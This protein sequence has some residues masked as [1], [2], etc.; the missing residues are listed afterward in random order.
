MLLPSALTILLGSLVVNPLWFLGFCMKYVRVVARIPEQDVYDSA[1]ALFQ[2]LLFVAGGKLTLAQL[3]RRDRK[4][5]TLSMWGIRFGALI[6]WCAA[7]LPF[8]LT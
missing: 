8:L 4:R 5:V 7:V 1:L 2:P 6:G 3:S